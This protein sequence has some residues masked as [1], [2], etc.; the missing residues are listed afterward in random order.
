MDGQV[1]HVC[2]EGEG[3]GDE[4]DAPRSVKAVP[5][6]SGV[7][8]S[9]PRG[10]SMYMDGVRYAAVYAIGPQPGRPIKVGYAIDVGERLS[11]LNV[12]HWNPLII[13]HLVWTPGPPVAKRIETEAHR[14]F[15]VAKVGIRG[16]WFDVPAK[17]ARDTIY[18][19]A[20]N[21]GLPLFSHKQAV[22]RL[23]HMQRKEWE[24][25]SRDVFAR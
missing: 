11:A 12:G 8:P 2:L 22:R 13:H 14:L 9:I 3:G 21:L 6:T 24:R 19:A 20:K 4:C 25:L 1:T 16:E 15:N 17:L 10:L 7:K 5:Q 23:E 18:V